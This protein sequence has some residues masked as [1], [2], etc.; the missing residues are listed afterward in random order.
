[1]KWREIASQAAYADFIQGKRK[2]SPYEIFKL[3]VLNSDNNEISEEKILKTV[4]KLVYEAAAATLL[5]GDFSSSDKWV[6][7]WDPYDRGRIMGWDSMIG[8]WDINTAGSREKL[9]KQYYAGKKQQVSP[10]QLYR[11]TLA[12]LDCK[13]FHNAPP[14]LRVNLES[15]WLGGKCLMGTARIKIEPG[16]WKLSGAFRYTDGIKKPA[17]LRIIVQPLSD[18]RFICFQFLLVDKA[19]QV[20]SSTPPHLKSSKV[21]RPERIVISNPDSQNWQTFTCTFEYPEKAIMYPYFLIYLK[22]GIPKGNFY[23]DDFKLEKL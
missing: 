5:N 12:N 6:D 2:K 18:G 4:R 14:S 21:I 9:L 16:K 10:W 11:R 13:V 23:L 1:L 3:S 22:K 15:G 20:R 8:K 7:Y 19:R 17:T